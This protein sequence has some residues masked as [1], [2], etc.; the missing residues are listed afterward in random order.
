MTDGNDGKIVAANLG[1]PETALGFLAEHEGETLLEDVDEKQL[2]RKVDWRLMPLMLMCYYL[3]YTDK[4]LS[5][6]PVHDNV[7]WLKRSSQ[8][9]GINGYR[10]RYQYAGEWLL[11]SG[12][13]LLYILSGLRASSSSNVPEIANCQVARC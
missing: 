1:D 4:T 11:S 12:Y 2:M 10:R 13:G 5:T 9:C 3:Q 7:T 6:Y 8:L